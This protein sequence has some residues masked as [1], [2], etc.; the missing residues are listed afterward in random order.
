MVSKKKKKTGNVCDFHAELPTLARLEEEA[1]KGRD[2]IQ[3]RTTGM[4]PYTKQKK[5]GVDRK[6]ERNESDRERT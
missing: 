2:V 1:G 3:F 6:L 5:G 4:P